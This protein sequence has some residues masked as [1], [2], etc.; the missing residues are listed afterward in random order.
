[1]PIPMAVWAA[2]AV[3]AAYV[4]Y[5]RLLPK[6]IPGVAY[7]PEAAVSMLGDLPSLLRDKDGMFEWM[8][9]Q[10]ARHPDS[11]LVQV[12]L[13]PFGGRPAVLLTD[14]RESQD[15]MVRR[16]REWDRSDWT[17]DLL[18]A[19]LPKHHVNLKT[20]PEW[21]AHRRLLQDLM[22]PSFLDRVAAPH[23]YAGFV[24]LIDLWRARARVSGGRPF[25]AEADIHHATLDAVLD[26]TFG[27]SYPHRAIPPQTQH[28]LSTEPSVSNSS[29]STSSNNNDGASADTPLDITYAPVHEAI[30]FM[31]HWTE[32]FKRVLDSPF[33][34]TYWLFHSMKPSE[35]RFRRRLTAFIGGQID[36]AVE[37]LESRRGKNEAGGGDDTAWVGSA[38]DMMVH[39]EKLL[40]EAEGREPVFKSQVMEQETVGFVIAGHDTSSTT[41]LWGLKLLADHPAVQTK[42]RDA[43]RAAHPAAAAEGRLPSVEE[44]ASADAAAALPY[45][46]AVIE[47]ILRVGGTIPGLDRTCA[48]D[49]VVLGRVL[50]AGT[51]LIMLSRGPSFTAP[52]A[53]AAAVDE[54]LRSDT[55]RKVAAA[56]GAA[57]RPEW[58]PEDVGRFVPERWLAAAAAR[59][60]GPDDAGAG[61][62]VFDVSAGPSMPF[63][64]GT[65]GCFGRRLAY[66]EQRVSLTLLVWSFEL[67]AC[68][69]ELSGYAAVDGLTHRPKQCYVR[70][71]P[72]GLVA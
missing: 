5:R 12:F 30:G 51:N 13:Q 18:G 72:T 36:M 7:N 48:R 29:S 64:L 3:L 59:G 58:D 42:L 35:V 39:R 65:R 56:G 15:I 60:N 66:L 54:A 49:S 53:A 34:G 43:L 45:L 40:A 41:L 20:G 68:P 9:K 26:F 1:M 55:S 17:I 4:L 52:P 50:P 25:A 14:F 61:A 31:Q 37:R 28:L 23:L 67:C 63:G 2:A 33:P 62:E 19:L 24:N 6:P 70:L 44:I 47:E 21:K 69:P 27:K 8:V 10:A 38:L 32:N 16:G 46:E 57:S 71:R 22:T 11:P